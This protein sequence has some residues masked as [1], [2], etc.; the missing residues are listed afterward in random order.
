WDGPER[1]YQ[2]QLTIPG[3]AN[4]IGA[5]LFGVPAI[6]IGHTDKMAWSHT[7]S[8]AWRFTPF[9]LK[10]VPGSPTTYLYDGQ[11]KEMTVDEV[12]VQVKQADGSLKPQTRKL[13]STL[14]GPI[15]TSILGL[16]L[17]P[18]TPERA[19]AI[20]D[21]NAGNFRYLNHFF[22]VNS[23]NSV[24][25]LDAIERRYQ[26]IPWVNTI[27]ADSTGTAYYA[28]IGAI[29]NVPDA[30]QSD[31]VNGALGVAAKGLIGLPI[32]DGSTSSCAWDNDPDAVVPGIFGP[33]HEPSLFRD[34]YV[35]NSNDSYWL[36][37]PKQPLEGFARMI[38]DE[39]TARTLRTRLGLVMVEDNKPFNTRK[40]QDTVFN[41]RQHAGELWKDDLV[42][43]CKANP[44]LVGT[45]GPV[46]V[47]SAC[48]VLEA[49]NVHDDLDSRGAILF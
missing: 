1:F 38:G 2:A 46:D 30:K 40:L 22:D 7:V 47:S 13:Y 24:R 44:M 21:V 8:T 26:G 28:D 34:D 15:L 12:T 11:P 33:G 10:L 45:S 5:S 14:Q 42:A 18:W 25:E 9:E 27:A 43:M 36:S 31:C 29:P 4:V 35:T 37:N 32:L 6:N 20:G 19:Y 39:R 16:P 49:W 48:P 17:F 3:R 23:A 41:N